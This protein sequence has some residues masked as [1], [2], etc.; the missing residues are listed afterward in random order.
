LNLT[1]IISMDFFDPASITLSHLSPKD[2]NNLSQVD[3][4]MYYSPLI[5]KVWRKIEEILGYSPDPEKTP[6][7]NYSDFARDLVSK[8][9]KYPKEEVPENFFELLEPTKKISSRFEEVCRLQKFIKAREARDTLIVWK[10]LQ[11]QADIDVDFSGAFESAEATI[12]FA[13]G[14][15]DWMNK[16]TNK[17]KLQR[18]THLDLKHNQ[19]ISVPI[20]LGKLANLTYLNLSNNQLISIP[21]ELGSLEKLTYLDL[22]HNRL[23]SVPKELES[24]ENLTCLNLYH[25]HLTSIPKELGN[26]INLT[27][28]F[29]DF[30]HLT[31]IPKEL[32]NLEKLEM[33]DIS[34]N[35]LTFIPKE[36]G[37]LKSLIY[38]CQVNNQLTPIPEVLKKLTNLMYLEMSCNHFSSIPDW[39]VKLE[40]RIV[41]LW[42]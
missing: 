7:R 2:L 17:K 4:A 6:T 16:D 1:E 40:N 8:I 36:L 13:K 27:Y 29:L 11:K 33:L 34:K 21:K 9:E 5:M 39:L 38:L 32:G 19:L 35:P 22:N 12:K 24:L 18:I 25:N 15:A 31:S 3:S 28:L 26:L 37:N 30:N 41:I 42:S 20:E 14:F 10:E 23:T